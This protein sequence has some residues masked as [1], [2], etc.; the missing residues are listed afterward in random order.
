MWAAISSTST[1]RESATTTSPT[2]RCRVLTLLA[3]VLTTTVG[4]PLVVTTADCAPVVLVAERGVAVAH[5]GWRGL[6]AGTIDYLSVS[7]VLRGPKRS[8]AKTQ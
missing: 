1:A 4:C 5:A 8:V 2:V 3:F 6:V 7:L